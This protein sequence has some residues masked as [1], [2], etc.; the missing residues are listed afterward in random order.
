[1]CAVLVQAA[2]SAQ[3]NPQQLCTRHHLAHNR[4]G[5]PMQL[6]ARTLPESRSLTHD[7]GGPPDGSYHWISCRSCNQAA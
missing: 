1:M 3:H 6:A 2:S 5:S 7:H 4:A